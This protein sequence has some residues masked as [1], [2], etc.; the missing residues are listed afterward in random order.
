MSQPNSAQLAQCER[1][2]RELVVGHH[3]IEACLVASDSGFEVAC[4]SRV[5]GF[6]PSRLSALISSARAL[7][8]AALTE[9]RCGDFTDIVIGGSQGRL[10]LQPLE[11]ERMLCLIATSEASVRALR[12]SAGNAAADI[13]AVLGQNEAWIK[14]Q[15]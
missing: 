11:G 10:V 12:Q 1:L 4:V 2:L 7:A 15:R 3:G 14:R 6:S 8:S 9:A 5:F 13:D